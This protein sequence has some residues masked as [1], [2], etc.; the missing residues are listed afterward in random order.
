MHRH[1]IA[2]AAALALVALAAPATAHAAP[3][4]FLS[5]ARATAASEQAE[6]I[7]CEDTASCLAVQLEGDATRV[8][9]TV[10]DHPYHWWTKS[11]DFCSA[12]IRVRLA[13]GKAVTKIV[14]TKRC[15]AL[16]ATDPLPF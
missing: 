4:S 16:T 12:T 9:A 15:H 6:R 10:V 11:S 3:A 14:G 8:S 13:R 5:T 7:F 2:T 1:R